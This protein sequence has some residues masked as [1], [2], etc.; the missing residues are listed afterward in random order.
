MQTTVSEILVQVPVWLDAKEVGD[1]SYDPTQSQ[2]PTTSW[3]NLYSKFF[4]FFGFQ[5]CQEFLMVVK[6]WQRDSEYY[7]QPIKSKV[8][9]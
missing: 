1:Q 2:S 8:I 5:P 4:I 9:Y 6:L 7:N 3:Q